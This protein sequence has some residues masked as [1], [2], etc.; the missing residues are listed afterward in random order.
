MSIEV[1]IVMGDASSIPSPI[2]LEISGMML[3]PVFQQYR[4]PMLNNT[5]SAKKIVSSAKTASI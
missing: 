1:G 4:I 3:I 5:R 2:S